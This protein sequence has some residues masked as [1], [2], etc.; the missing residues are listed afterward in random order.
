MSRLTLNVGLEAPR[1]RDDRMEGWQRFALVCGW[2]VDYLIGPQ[3]AKAR[4]TTGAS[5]LVVQGI[6]RTFTTMDDLHTLC[7]QANQ[8]CIA[9]WWA[10][11]SLTMLVGPGRKH[12]L[13]FDHTKFITMEQA[14]Y[15][16]HIPAQ[17]QTDTT[18]APGQVV[19]PIPPSM[20]YK[21]A[22]GGYPG[23]VPTTPAE[24]QGLKIVN[25]Q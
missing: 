13:P 23:H 10:Q 20:L 22:H 19:N 14:M 18:K 2:A 6:E 17:H 3:I 4:D 12:Y 25:P 24:R 1:Y 8:D 16:L 11:P 5:V 9:V 15:P 7:D 21:P